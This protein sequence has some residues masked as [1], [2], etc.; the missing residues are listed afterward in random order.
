MQDGRGSKSHIK[1]KHE[2]LQKKLCQGKRKL[3]GGNVTSNTKLRND[4]WQCNYYQNISSS[5]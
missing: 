4:A 3:T 1:Q 5:K 2:Y